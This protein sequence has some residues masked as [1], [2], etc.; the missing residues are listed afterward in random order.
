MRFII[1]IGV[2]M[3][4]FCSA[5]QAETMYVSDDIKITLRTGQGIDHK[6][7]A[8]IKSGQEVEVL[9]PDDEWTQ[10]KLLN[11]ME[12]WVLTRFLTYD[13]PC[14]LELEILK[15]KYETL[16]AQS[17]FLLKENRVYKEESKRLRAEL[18]GSKEM[19]VAISKSYD[20]LKKESADFLELK[21]KYEL[22]SSQLS[23]QTKKAEELE[24]ELSKLLSHRSIIWFL[25]GAG[26][27]ILGILIGFSAKR[28]R[29]KSSLS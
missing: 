16:S 9:Q 3:I 6:I 29:R 14:R 4:L 26:V 22:A 25:S 17:A 1:F 8:M 7:S 13:K 15:K 21:S 2:C 24:E 12:G 5:A 18:S 10:V 27:L 23:D 19:L 28:Q 20:T 11:G